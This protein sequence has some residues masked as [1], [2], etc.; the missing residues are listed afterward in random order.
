[1]SL[2]RRREP[3]RVE[4]AAEFFEAVSVQRADAAEYLEVSARRT[5]AGEDARAG[6]D[7]SREFGKLAGEIRVVRGIDDAERDGGGVVA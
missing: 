6:G 4:Q 1:M 2:S 5:A 3:Q 7:Q